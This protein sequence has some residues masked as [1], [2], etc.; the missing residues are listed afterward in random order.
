MLM[1]LLLATGVSTNV[2]AARYYPSINAGPIVFFSLP[3]AGNGTYVF[4]TDDLK[5]SSNPCI[6]APDT[7]L[8]V[9]APDGKFY[10]NDN[11]LTSKR[12]RVTFL[13][14]SGFYTVYV[15]AAT[16]TRCGKTDVYFTMPGGTRAKF[17]DDVEFGGKAIQPTGLPSGREYVFQT[18]HN[19]GGPKTTQILL[20]SSDWQL[21][22]QN[23]S[24]GVLGAARL[25]AV[26]ASYDRVVVGTP[27]LSSS[28][29]STA[30]LIDDCYY[31]PDTENFA[32]RT[33]CHS[34]GRD[35]DSDNLSDAL[36]AELGTNPKRWDTDGDGLFD[37]HEVVGRMSA[38]GD[39]PLRMLGANPRRRDLFVEVDSRYQKETQAE[40]DSTPDPFPNPLSEAA[41]ESVQARLFDLPRLPPNPDG[42]HGI[43]LHVDRGAACTNGT[44]CG[45]WGGSQNWGCAVGKRGVAQ[46]A[47]IYEITCDDDGCNRP[48]PTEFRKERWELFRYALRWPAGSG[49]SYGASL[50]FNGSSTILAHEL[51]HTMGLAHWG[52][53]TL[54]PLNFKFNYPS[55]MNYAF[56]NTSGS[57]FSEGRFAPIDHRAMNELQWS[58][59]LDKSYL[60]ASKFGVRVCQSADQCPGAADPADAV[61]W[62]GDGRFTAGGVRF[63]ISPLNT[64][65][66]GAGWP[67]KHDAQVAG[68]PPRLAAAASP[69]LAYWEGSP[70]EFTAYAFYV[71]TTGELRFS[72][73]APGSTVWSA[74]AS[75][76]CPSSLRTAERP[77]RQRI[78]LSI[79]FSSCT[80]KRAPANWAQCCSIPKAIR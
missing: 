12:S 7:Q 61:D 43:F 47:A 73:L 3:L 75:L 46:Y 14:S 33:E 21:K 38:A 4:E 22:A 16:D 59:G 56:Q 1:M 67:H 37:Y 24:G 66:G 71:A 39:V 55:I 10:S 11:Y 68:A 6:G 31:T 32:Q 25:K 54:T 44:L 58:P 65:L 77:R 18:A 17:L 50:W 48:D 70:G 53:P 64:G 51:G 13:G 35:A 26:Y 40:C 42:T 79:A 5:P 45:D 76:P 52:S 30:L 28:R 62:N 2:A 27:M 57:R 74:W 34:A 15:F 80:R 41:I 8:V 19:P 36:E 9:R 29:G 69:A 60:T 63:D 72:K 49:Q 20:F 78:P 23:S